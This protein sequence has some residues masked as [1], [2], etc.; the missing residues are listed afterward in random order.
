MGF[1][2]SEEFNRMKE[3]I[4]DLKDKVAYLETQVNGLNEIESSRQAWVDTLN[5]GQEDILLLVKGMTDANKKRDERTQED[6]DKNKN[7]KIKI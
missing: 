4:K 2:T 6:A 3:E 7:G 5:R 1:K